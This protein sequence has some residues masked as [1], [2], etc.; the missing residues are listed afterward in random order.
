MSA[1]GHR[2]EAFE[3]HGQPLAVRLV[4]GTVRQVNHLSMQALQSLQHRTV[5]MR[6]QSVGN[7]KT[8]V[9]IDADQ[10]CI[11]RGVMYFRERN[12]MR[13]DGLPLPF[14]GISDDMGCIE[15]QRLWKAR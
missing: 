9:G 13:H 11:E 6:K 10:M 1:L 4:P 2:L 5:V 12:A 7:M 3:A 14:I 8:G 15:Q